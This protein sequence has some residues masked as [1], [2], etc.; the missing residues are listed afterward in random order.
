MTA[1]IKVHVCKYPDRANLMLRYR[2]PYTGRH[3]CKTAGTA[4][5]KEAIG[6]AAV[7]QD[8]LRSGR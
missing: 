7:W 2:D 6:A 4:S 5:E 3:V 1:E 8:E